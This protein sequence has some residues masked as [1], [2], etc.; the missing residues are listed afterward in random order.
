METKTGNIFFE[1][2]SVFGNESFFSERTE[3]FRF[4]FNGKEKTD[5]LYGTGNAYDYGARMYDPRLGIWL[6]TDP[7]QKKYPFASP[8]SSF[9]DNPIIFTD[10][11]KTLELGGDTKT[12]LV[13]IQSL[14]PQQYRSQIQINSSGQIIFASYDKL[15]DAT[16]NYEGVKLVN[17][18][19]NS[20]NKYKY[21]VGNYIKA[22]SRGGFLP[23]GTNESSGYPPSRVVKQ[24]LGAVS[25]LSIT[26]R[27]DGTSTTDDLMPEKGYAGSVRLS[28]GT[29]YTLNKE[30]ENVVHDRNDV[31]FHELKENF[32]RTE[33]NGGKG[34]D[35]NSAHNESA[36]KAN[37][38]SN[39]VNHK[40]DPSPGA[41]KNFVPDKK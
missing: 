3:G 1:R 17:D 14:V 33:G 32:L 28:K 38:F 10:N 5:E 23:K 21:S 37:K 41:N 18:L 35:Y 6:S 16:K 22:T 24:V 27:G 31:V 20:S 34:M 15:P 9:G 39:E 11:G 19:I 26:P 12:A 40:N 2:I 4:G 36:S 30:E 7:A 13:D 25:N 8:F 29:F